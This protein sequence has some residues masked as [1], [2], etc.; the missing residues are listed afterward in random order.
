MKARLIKGRSSH[1]AICIAAAYTPNNAGF[2][3]DIAGRR[4]VEEP[5][6][7][8]GKSNDQHEKR[9]LGQVAANRINK[10]F[11]AHKSMMIAYI[12]AIMPEKQNDIKAAYN[13]YY[14]A[15]TQYPGSPGNELNK[16][17]KDLGLPEIDFNSYLLP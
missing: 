11:L 14:V 5:E 10:G 9:M 13:S 6:K 1:I 8:I 2:L 17:L 4:H 16:K 12:D 3:I 7:A 15:F